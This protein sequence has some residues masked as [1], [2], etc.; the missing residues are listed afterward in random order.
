MIR[1]SMRFGSK[2]KS[3]NLEEDFL[4]VDVGT[5][6]NMILGCPTLHRYKPL[7]KK[8]KREKGRG[9]IHR[10]LHYLH[11]PPPQRPRP[12]CLGLDGL[13]PYVL[14]LGRRRDKLNLFRVTA[15]ICGPLTLIHIVK[16]TSAPACAS[17]SS[18]WRYNPFF[19]ASRASRSARSFSQRRWH[20]V[21]SPSNLRHSAAALT[22]QAKTS[23]MAVPSSMTLGGSEAPG[24]TKSYYLTKS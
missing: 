22:S 1:L 13:V 6:Y 20:R 17:T 10:T 7:K 14:T 23:S 8:E 19:S 11:S 15:L 9:V 18:S 5:A 21:K 2:L 3:K 12:Q 16:A 24:V 4:V